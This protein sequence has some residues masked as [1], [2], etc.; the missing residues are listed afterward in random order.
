MRGLL[1]D[2]RFA[3]RMLVKSPG[4]TLV[5]VLT[6]ALAIGV[7]TAIFSVVNNVLIRP[8]PY[9][10]PD[11]LV[12]TFEAKPEVARLPVPYPNYLDYRA[13][14]SSF[15]TTAALGLH[16][17][18][19][20]GEGDPERFLVEAV[21]HEFMPML[22]VTP[23]LGRNFAPEE[24]APNGPK[25]V[26]LTHGMWTRQF[27]ADPAIVGRKVVLDGG[28]W[29]I[30]GVLPADYRPFAFPT[31][32]AFIPL[33]TRADEPTYRDRAARPELYMFGR[34]KPG[35]TLTQARADLQAIGDQLGQRFPDQVGS[36]RPLVMSLHDAMVEDVATMLLL[37]F[38]AV[39][40]VL[41]IAA[42]NVANLTLE[43]A[44]TRQRELSI[45]AALGA[46]RW[47]LIRQMLVESSL[48]ALVGGALGTLVALWS[49]DLI[50][51]FLPGIITANLSGTI[52]VDGDALV[53][54]TAVAL[55]TGLLFGLVPA[56]F[57]SRQQLAQVLKD[58]DRHA[59]AGGRH[60]RA[61]N[62]L[63]V[64]EVALALM[65]AVAAT[66]SMRSLADL[67]R[68][69]PGFKP[70]HVLY[71]ILTLPP[72]R[73]PTPASW[74]Q[75]WTETRR[76][77]GAIPGVLSV[78]VSSGAPGMIGAWEPFYPL[79][80][81]RS[82][83]NSN[84]ALTYRTDLDFLETLEIPLLAGRACGPQDGP[85]TP[86]VVLVSRRLAEKFF[87]GQ[88][89]VGQRLQDN[90]SKQPSVEIVGVVGD[91]KH[92][93]LGIP[94]R[95]PYQLHYCYQQ[96]PASSQQDN[97]LGM[98]MHLLARTEGDPLALTAQ[99]RD[100]IA[101]IDPRGS[102]LYFSSLDE[103]MAS[104]LQPRRFTAQLLGAFAGIALLLAAVGLYA[105]MANTVVQRTHELGVRMALGAQPR[106][107][108]AL[109]VRQGMRVV[110]VGLVIGLLGALAL[111]G[112][113]TTLLSDGI[114]ATD[115]PT[116]LGVSLLIVAVGLLAT[117]LPARRATRIDP[118]VALRRE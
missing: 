27:A 43:R 101:A 108:V 3:V 62:L 102:G 38:G 2:L 45:R 73:Y 22:G 93:G 13:G 68:A 97:V 8:L 37:L 69:D 57:A 34:M 14:N 112:T 111:T 94:D 63:V 115:P 66:L 92:E 98:S 52:A 6:L 53:Y 42:A 65:L 26:L 51:A 54:T 49:V 71:S 77:V 67:H 118:M 90:L 79:G 19:L 7:N 29:T 12:V 70:D 105:V 116:Y 47:R 1:N 87:P 5:A 28:P 80:V 46:G 21:S 16:I 72:D 25:A 82:P 114:A 78:S 99:V 11:Q 32:A 86:A 95:T 30:V 4:Y 18:T 58:T 9:P 60:L 96:L 113:M 10:D 31:V 56:L 110:V 103:A 55:G 83:E 75:F 41:L 44:M 106:D 84:I 85:D 64:V 50:T 20:T 17:M 15:S 117:Y 109:V 36:S 33:G 35:V 91:V 74:A 100:A 88:D 24:D 89:P 61:R 39:G 107:V 48:L 81:A 23:V 40:C 104:S 59:S 76:R